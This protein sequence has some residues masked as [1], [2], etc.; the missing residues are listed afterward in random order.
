MIL[1]KKPTST[2]NKIDLNLCDEGIEDFPSVQI[3]LEC[4]TWLASLDPEPKIYIPVWFHKGL[5][6]PPPPSLPL[7]LIGPGTGCAPFRGF[8]EERAVQSLYGPIA[9]IILFFGCRNENDFLYREL[10]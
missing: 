3:P 4:S 9:P 10:W 8:V 5:L 2:E 1:K 7:I 6:P